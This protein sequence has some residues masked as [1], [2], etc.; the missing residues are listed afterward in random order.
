MIGH[1]E[2]IRRGKR[3]QKL[4][5]ELA[6]DTGMH[7]RLARHFVE[8]QITWNAE[9][10]G[11][12]RPQAEITYDNFVKEARIYVPPELLPL[13]KRRKSMQDNYPPQ[14]PALALPELRKF[15]AKTLQGVELEEK[16]KRV[17]RCQFPGWDGEVRDPE[18]D[19]KKP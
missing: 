16:L 5:E 4:A 10:Q 13:M 14:L 19:R 6:R 9:Q 15:Y 1:R 3:I 11:A 8:C 18:L 17:M 7:V 12:G 2:R